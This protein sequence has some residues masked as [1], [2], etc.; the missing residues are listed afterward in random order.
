M[1]DAPDV[2]SPAAL[3]SAVP[4]LCRPKVILTTIAT[5]PLRIKYELLC[6]KANQRFHV[7]ASHVPTATERRAF[8]LACRAATMGH[9]RV[10]LDRHYLHATSHTSSLLFLLRAS[11]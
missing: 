2:P 1:G 10:Q 6:S 5:P 8:Q 9:E 4:E 3:L 7:Q 11:D